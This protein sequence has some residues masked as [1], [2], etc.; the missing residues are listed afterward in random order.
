MIPDPGTPLPFYQAMEAAHSIRTSRT[1]VTARAAEGGGTDNW[2]VTYVDVHVRRADLG[3]FVAVLHPPDETEVSFSF[4]DKYTA[5]VAVP[6]RRV[7]IHIPPS[8]PAKKS[9]KRAG[10]TTSAPRPGG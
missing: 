8:E 3:D 4:K 5:L 7:H 9:K 1:S 10:K 6:I 2:H